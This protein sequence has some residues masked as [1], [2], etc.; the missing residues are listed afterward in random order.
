LLIARPVR[1]KSTP[2]S[3]EE[4]LFAAFAGWDAAG[5]KLFAELVPLRAGPRLSDGGE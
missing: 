4:I 1:D 2:L 5:A 3:P